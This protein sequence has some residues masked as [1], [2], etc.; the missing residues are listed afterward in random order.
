V[1][2]RGLLLFLYLTSRHSLSD[3][4]INKVVIYLGKTGP[5][6]LRGANLLDEPWSAGRGRLPWV[7]GGRDRECGRWLAGPWSLVTGQSRSLA[8]CR[9]P[10]SRLVAPHADKLGFLVVTPL[11]R[12]ACPQGPPGPRT[13]CAAWAHSTAVQCATHSGLLG[14]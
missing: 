8:P 6:S 4:S 12:A 5:R 2:R 7:V 1:Q 9:F 13:S 14:F 3:L 10:Q 11:Q